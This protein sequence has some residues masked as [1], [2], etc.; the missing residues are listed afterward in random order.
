MSEHRYVVRKWVKP[1][2]L[3]SHGA[4]FGGRLLEW[5]DEDGAI[6]AVTQLGTSQL[7]T[8][9]MSEINFLARADRGDLLE[10]SYRVVRFGRTSITL[11]CQVQNVITGQE[12]LTLNEIVFVTVDPDG[13]PT[14]HGYTTETATTDRISP[15]PA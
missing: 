4:L 5:V 1:E 13:A 9:H 12:I 14:P 3:N 6:L 8:R 7:V 10:L 11:S 15:A 2:D